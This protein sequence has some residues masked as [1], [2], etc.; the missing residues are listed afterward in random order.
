M[1]FLT[2]HIQNM[3]LNCIPSY[4]QPEIITFKLLGMW[5]KGETRNNKQNIAYPTSKIN[6]NQ[7]WSIA[8]W[9][10]KVAWLNVQGMRL[11]RQILL[12]VNSNQSTWYCIKKDMSLQQTLLWEHQISSGW[13]SFLKSYQYSH[14]TTL[15]SK[16]N[17]LTDIF[18]CGR[19]KCCNA[20]VYFWPELTLSKFL[21][22][23]VLYYEAKNPF[24]QISTSYSSTYIPW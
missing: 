7:T 4:Q 3:P 14:H 12:L 15:C 5:H 23:K 18:S 9:G 11:T 2:H 10:L 22:W 17:T 16:W 21:F 13:T 6:S 8:V 19:K 20:G 1:N 24:D